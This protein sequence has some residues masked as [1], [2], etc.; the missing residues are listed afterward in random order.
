MRELVFHKRARWLHQ[1]SAMFPNH[2]P[3]LL[4]DPDMVRIST[5]REGPSRGVKSCG[6]HNGPLSVLPFETA[7]RQSALLCVNHVID[8]RC[9]IPA[10]TNVRRRSSNRQPCE[11]STFGKPLKTVDKTKHCAKRTVEEDVLV[12]SH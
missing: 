9:I 10:L 4:K 5:K 8:V 2:L 3:L 6:P 11:L 7:F 12:R 1:H